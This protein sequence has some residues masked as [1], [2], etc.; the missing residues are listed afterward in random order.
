MRRGTEENMRSA[1][2]SSTMPIV[3]EDGWRG[4]GRERA[5]SRRRAVSAWVDGEGG[6]RRSVKSASERKGTADLSG[7]RGS[8]T[9]G[10][11]E[12]GRAEGKRGDGL[13]RP[14]GRRGDMAVRLRFVRRK[15]AA[16]E[17]SN[18]LK[19]SVAALGSVV[20][21]IS[22]VGGG[23]VGMKSGVEIECILRGCRW[24]GKKDRER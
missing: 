9:F 23:G 10:E 15:A 12:G 14:G 11:A 17:S 24:D 6:G 3:F 18:K 7:V 22:R 1:A 16:K 21:Y 13:K 5:H 8:K 2:T 19:L 20:A 4:A